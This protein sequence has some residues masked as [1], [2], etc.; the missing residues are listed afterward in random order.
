VL[1]V[2]L[3]QFLSEDELRAYGW[4]I[5]FVVGAVAAVISLFLRVAER[6]HQQ[7]NAREQGRR[8]HPRAVP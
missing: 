2:I 1:V 6:N 4:R 5:P 3:Q 7:G 8:Q